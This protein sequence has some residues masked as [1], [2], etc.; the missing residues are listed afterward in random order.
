MEKLSSFDFDARPSRS[1]Y[2]P[3]VKALVDENTFAVKIKRGDP[4]FPEKVKVA[5]IQ[6]GVRTEVGKTGKTARTRIL[7]ADEIVVGLD[8]NPTSR[9]R[10]T[11]R[12]REAVAA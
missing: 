10:S 2:V 7:S 1:R 11:K 4:E 6:A 9:R 5:T 3:V 8:P 12:R